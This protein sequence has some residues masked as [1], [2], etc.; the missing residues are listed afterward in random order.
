MV[1]KTLVFFLFAVQVF[2]Y[3]MAQITVVEAPLFKEPNLESEV[4]QYLYKGE[5][6]PLHPAEIFKDPYSN[7]MN[8]DENLAD[9]NLEELKRNESDP[10]FKHGPAYEPDRNSL[11]YKTSDNLG[12]DVWILKEHVFVLYQDSRELEHS[13]VKPD[14]T[15]YVLADPLPP[16]Y[17]LNTRQ[18]YR[19][20]FSYGL[21]PNTRSSY[22]YEFSINDQGYNYDRSLE[23]TW[24]KDVKWDK[25]QRTFFGFHLTFQFGDSQYSMDEGEASEEYSLV[26]VGPRLEYDVWKADKYRIN[27]NTSLQMSLLDE[28]RI[29]ISSKDDAINGDTRNFISGF[30]VIP[31]FGANIQ[32]EKTVGNMDLLGGFNIYFHLPNSY[33]AED[34]SEESQWWDGNTFEVPFYTNINFFLGLQATI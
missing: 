32:R 10:L 9:K 3:N 27:L 14:P 5:K 22:P 28:V 29:K 15:D 17:P 16:G 6:I 18:G 21:G 8:L 23:F 26:T 1:A 34:S 7:D 20:Y 33:V 13:T 12:N 19:S 30:Q 4:V 2:A 24:V 25:R 31:T 11:F